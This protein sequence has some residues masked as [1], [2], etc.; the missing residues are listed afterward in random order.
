[1]SSRVVDSMEGS[2]V[3]SVGAAAAVAV[4]GLMLWGLKG[5]V[6]VGCSVGDA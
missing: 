2:V 4:V 5:A 1:M 6:G 3:H